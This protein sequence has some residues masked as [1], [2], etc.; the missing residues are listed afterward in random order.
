MEQR[1]FEQL[2]GIALRLAECNISDIEIREPKDDEPQSW[3]ILFNKQKNK[4]ELL[5]HNYAQA[6]YLCYGL[7]FGK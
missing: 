1:K 4:I 2:H 7:C 5:I 6:T 3:A